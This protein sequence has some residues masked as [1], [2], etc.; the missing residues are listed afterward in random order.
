MADQ[1]I[2]E[3]TELTTPV[4][5]DM[6]PIV[7]DPSGT[8]ATKKVTVKNLGEAAY[9]HGLAYAMSNVLYRF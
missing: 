6:V 9:P 7:S 8:P 4:L 5:T 2:T 3:L 1:K